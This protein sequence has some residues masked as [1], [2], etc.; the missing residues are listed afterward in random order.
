MNVKNLLMNLKTTLHFVICALGLLVI[1]TSLAQPD[2]GLRYDGTNSFRF[3][4]HQAIGSEQN[5]ERTLPASSEYRERH[6]PK[7]VGGE[8]VG[9]LIFS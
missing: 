6:L 7:E 3:Q 5:G 8:E 9:R 4:C 2:L 1:Q